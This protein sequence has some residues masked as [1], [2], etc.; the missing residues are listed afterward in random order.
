MAAKTDE[1][2]PAVAP[3]S[4]SSPVPSSG[5]HQLR[6]VKFDYADSFACT[7]IVSVVAASIAEL[8]TYPLDL[9]KTRL[10][11]QGEGAAQ[12]AVKSNR[13]ED[14]QLRPDAQGVHQERQPGAAGLE[15]GAVRRHRRSR[16]PVAGLAR[17]PGQGANPDGGQAAADGRT[18]QGPLRWSRLPEDRAT[19]RR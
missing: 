19:G 6:P 7:Y 5:R 10:Q 9:T 18:A 13:C 15:V 14:L 11:I 8:A 17:R 12:T 16:C 2:S 4:S 3:A 1:S